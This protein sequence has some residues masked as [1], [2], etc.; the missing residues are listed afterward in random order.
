MSILDNINTLKQSIENYNTRINALITEALEKN[1]T[2]VTEDFTLAADGI[3]E[4]NLTTL[5][6]TKASEYNLHSP[7]VEIYVRDSEAVG[8]VVYVSADAVASV[9]IV[10]SNIVR[11]KNSFTTSLDFR[12]RIDVNKSI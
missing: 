3:K 1:I 11:I 12:I 5:I 10:D 8:E 9:A 4:Y 6:G 7:D 2:V